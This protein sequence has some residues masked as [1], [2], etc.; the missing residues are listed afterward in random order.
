MNDPNSPSNKKVGSPSDSAS[1]AHPQIGGTVMIPA[2]TEDQLPKEDVSSDLK[3]FLVVTQGA[4]EGRRIGI[5]DQPVMIGRCCGDVDLQD[6]SV[7][8]RHCQ[9]TLSGDELIIQDLGS[10]NGTLVDRR[11]IHEPT[12]LTIG[13]R[14]MIGSTELLHELRSSSELEQ[15]QEIDLELD[16]AAFYVESLLPAP[17]KSEDVQLHYLFK[18]CSKLGGDAFCF[19]W[20]DDDHLAFY[21]IDVCGHGVRSALHSVSVVQLLRSCSLPDVDFRRP[22]EV[23]EGLN[24]VFQMEQHD[25]MYFTAWYGVYR[26]TDRCLRYGSAGHPP[27]LLVDGS[28]SSQLG[29]R[30]PFIGM[31]EDLDF[32]CDEVEIPQGSRLFVFSDGAFE[33][34]KTD[35]NDWTMEELLDLFA[36]CTEDSPEKALSSIEKQLCEIQGHDQFADDLSIMMVDF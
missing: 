9:V 11:P 31:M 25:G 4:D 5:G 2:F 35:Q 13:H 7:S 28:E 22:S 21:L 15:H 24:R 18:P 1:A 14:L 36:Q 8:S 16:R 6:P 17:F 33:L 10:S 29:M 23:L 19:Q 26:R 30:Q 12:P 27:A 20:L 32:R 34:V 3:H